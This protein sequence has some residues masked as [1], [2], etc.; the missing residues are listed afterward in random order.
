[1]NKKLIFG[2]IGAVLLIL[3]IIFVVRLRSG[4]P[5]IPP[6]QRDNPSVEQPAE[7]NQPIKPE[8]ESE[9]PVF[10]IDE[11]DKDADGIDDAKEAELGTSDYDYDSDN[12]GLSDKSEIERWKTD[13]NNQDSDGDGFKDGYE[14]INGY[15]PAGPGRLE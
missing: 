3:V 2:I 13:P 11:N 5:E 9:E 14:V 1:M 8:P 4:S 12:D 6:T 7:P 10:I 15:N